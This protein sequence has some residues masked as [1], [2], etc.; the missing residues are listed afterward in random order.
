[1][2]TDKRPVPL[3]HFL[4]TGKGGATRDNRYLILDAEKWQYPGYHQAKESLKKS[5]QQ[6]FVNDRGPLHPKQEQQI[7]IG[8]I[9]HLKRH[10]LLPVV[11]FTFSR[12]KCDNNAA[13]LASLDLTTQKEK[14]LIRMFFD[15]CVRC[16]K[17]ED[18]SIPQIVHMK[19]IL[20]R[21]VGV[22]HSGILPIIKEIVEMLFQNGHI[23]VW[24]IIN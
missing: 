24:N 6:K 8:L 16:L 18:R 22:H 10:D 23:K 20:V 14:A 21:G 12:Q 17:K 11:A 15:K 1:M 3:Q 5:E 2:T 19:E 9:D 13:N 7:W 4:Y